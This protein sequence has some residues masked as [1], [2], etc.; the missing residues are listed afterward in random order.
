M[1]DEIT[2]AVGQEW[3]VRDWDGNVQQMRCIEDEDTEV[4]QFGYCTKPGTAL[5]YCSPKTFRAW[6]HRTGAVLEGSEN[7]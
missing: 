7:G 2:L 5:S 6:I 1:P 4:A 3:V